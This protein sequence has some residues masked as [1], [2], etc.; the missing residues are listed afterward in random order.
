MNPII[1]DDRLTE[2]Q[3]REVGRDMRERV[4]ARMSGVPEKGIHVEYLGLRYLVLPEV[5]WPHWD[6]VP[7]VRNFEVNPGEYVLDLCTGSGVIAINAARK[8]ADSV[9][10]ID[11][12]PAAVR[13][14]RKN[15]ADHKYSSVIDVRGGNLFDALEQDD[16]F[17]V[18][19]ANTP[20]TREPVDNIAEA[21]F[22]DPDLSLH[23]RLFSGAQ[24]HL[25]KGGRL[26]LANANFGTVDEMYK[27]AGENGFGIELIGRMRDP[28]MPIKVYYA[29]ELRR[30]N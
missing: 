28:V 8:G 23:K 16:R 25:R 6:S 1:V 30:R 26:Y 22:G 11:I 4:L 19:T 3:M 14:T 20:F 24:K 29:F 12:N 7:L 18:I 10:A 15:V 9:V 21:A 5:F 2:E 17:D 27:L 13:C